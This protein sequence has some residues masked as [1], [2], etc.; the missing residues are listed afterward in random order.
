M[1]LNQ[2]LTLQKIQGI[3]NKSLIALIEFCRVNHIESVTDLQHLDLSHISKLKRAAAS[4]NKFFTA[5]LLDATFKECMSDLENWKALSVQV[6]VF[7]SSY[8]PA[9]LAELSDPPAILFCRGNLELLKSARAIAV[10]G[11]RE[12]TRL[13]EANAQRTVAYFSKKEF[14][15]VS[16]LALGIDSIAHRAA[17]ENKG[18]TIAVLV[19]VINVSPTQ[20]LKLA[21]QIL[22][23]EGLLI[24]E[25]PPNTK[26]IPALFVK[27]DRIQSGLAMAVF[28]I[29]TTV[30]GGT[31][32]A[33]KA[34]N[35]LLRPVYVPDAVA[36]KYASLDERAMSGTQMLLNE[37]RAKAYSR[38]TYDEITSE[39][40]ILVNKWTPIPRQ[41]DQN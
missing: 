24:S 25:N 28:A 11:T 13:G 38:D 1:Q 8:Y 12:N 14:C 39:L 20:N 30:D 19:D 21:D 36:A 27:R 15:I 9:Q 37:G 7:G 6:V 32:H 31:M 23:N 3:G 26:V 17:L 10:V 41:T 2:I 33:V 18:A 4:L 40:N 29:E 16:G 35:L 22:R 34:A 5:G